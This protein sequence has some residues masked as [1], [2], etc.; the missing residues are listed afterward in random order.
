MVTRRS[1]LKASALL[2]AGL[3]EPISALG[4]PL[5]PVQKGTGQ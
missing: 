3:K 5:P 1:F 4:I 2:Y